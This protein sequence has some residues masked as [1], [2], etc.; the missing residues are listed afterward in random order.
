MNPSPARP[1]GPPADTQIIALY[2]SGLSH[3]QTATRLGIAPGTVLRALARHGVARRPHGG[4]RRPARAGTQAP[5]PGLQPS[6][7][8]IIGLYQSGLSQR[9]T[10]ARLGISH[11]TVIRVLRRHDVSPRP[12]GYPSPASRRAA[13]P[14]ADQE[15]IALYQSGL[16][17]DQTAAKTGTNPDNVRQTLIRHGIARRPPGF[18]RPTLTSPPPPPGTLLSA[19]QA[20][21][22]LS[23]HKGTVYRLIRQGKITT[24]AGTRPLR[25]PASA[26]QPFTPPADPQRPD[27]DHPRVSVTIRI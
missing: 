10:A 18:P 19:A 22:L 25:I 24:A 17:L 23:V 27:S 12:R 4:V 20:A 1:A 26:L 14:A 5:R 15:T 2:A 16:T 21:A 3:R 8:Q 11:M 13:D 7:Q 9:Q 6:D